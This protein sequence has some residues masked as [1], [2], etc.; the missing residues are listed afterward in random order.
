MGRWLGVWGPPSPRRSKASQ[1][2]DAPSRRGCGSDTDFIVNFLGTQNWLDALAWAA[3]AA[4]A[5]I[6]GSQCHRRRPMPT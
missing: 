3:A 4:A 1:R 5:A 6:G 2:A